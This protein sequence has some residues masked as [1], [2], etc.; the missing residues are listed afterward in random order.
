MDQSHQVVERENND[1]QCVT[2]YYFSNESSFFQHIIKSDSV[3]LTLKN[4]T[5]YL[6]LFD[7]V[8]FVPVV[9]VK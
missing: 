6:F 2:F 4:L 9:I 8:V 1:M 5:S 3:L 7:I